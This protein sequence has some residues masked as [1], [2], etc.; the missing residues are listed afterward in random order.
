MSNARDTPPKFDEVEVSIFGPGKGESVAVHLGDNEWIIVDSCVDQESKRIPVL[1][2]L[3]SLG[4]DP[5][6]SVKLVVGTHAHDDHIAGLAEVLKACVGA[7]FICSAALTSEEFFCM[8]EADADIEAQLRTSVRQEYRNIFDQIA[9]RR[10]GK[11]IKRAIEELVLFTRPD[12]GRAPSAEVTA[13]SPSDHAITRATQLLAAGCAKKDQRRR[14]AAVNP[15]ELAVAL[16]VKVGQSELI[17]GADL[18]VGPAGCGW[19]AVLNTFDLERRPSLLK[20]PHHGAK[21]A[22]HPEVWE[23]LLAPDVTSVLAPFRQGNVTLPKSSD[24]VRLKQRSS[25]VYSS[26]NPKPP[27]AGKVVKNARAALGVLATNIRTPGVSGQ[28]RARKSAN[29][30]GW[31]VETF[32]PGM[33]L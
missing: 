25:S 14:L 11:H 6:Q 9:S 2:Y 20:V 16:W 30:D 21:N 33:K 18:L 31:T 3:R 27:P 26:A 4:V 8:L 22:D 29:A 17:L 5:A 32:W 7:K 23:K 13:L 1:D 12:S 28:V 10:P 19:Q 15:N 24:V